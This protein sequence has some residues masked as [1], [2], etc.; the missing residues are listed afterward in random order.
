MEV[1]MSVEH[2][3]NDINGKAES[4]Q[5]LSP[6]HFVQHTFQVELP[7]IETGSV[8]WQASDFLLEPW[9]GPL[10]TEFNMNFI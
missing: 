7:G 5:V 1:E 4:L 8:R 9:H 10:K 2:W 6:G 3:W